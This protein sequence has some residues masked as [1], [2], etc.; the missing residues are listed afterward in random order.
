MSYPTPPPQ[1]YHQQAY[2]PPPSQP[3]HPNGQTP[4]A[5]PP[6][7]HSQY[8]QYQ[9]SVPPPDSQYGPPGQYLAQGQYGNVA[10]VGIHQAPYGGAAPY[11][12]SVPYGHAPP[13][14][15]QPLG[16]TYA[17]QPS[18]QQQLGGG[19]Y[20][21]PTPPSLG[22]IPSQ[23]VQWD[24]TQD[25]QLL[26]KAMKGFGTNEATLIAILSKRDPL[27]MAQIRRRYA[28]LYSGT[29]ESRIANE[30]SG[31]FRECLLALVRGPLDQDA[32]NVSR[33]VKG[34]GTKE[35]LLNDVLL[36]RSNADLNAI[37][38]R[39]LEIQ[40]SPLERKVSEDLSA[41]TE[42]LFAMVLAAQRAEESAPVVPQ[43]I[44]HD[45]RELQ[46]A[47][48]GRHGTDQL[49]VC[50]ILCSKSDGQLRAVANVYR[51]A[52]HRNLEDV[53]KKEFSGHMEDALLMI[54]RGGVDRAMRDATLLEKAMAGAGTKDDLL[55]NR[56]VRF[57][58]DR[59]HM[60]QVKGA[61][62]HKYGKELSS[63]IK[64]ETH[65]DYEKILLACIE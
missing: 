43:Q 21:P 63:R 4:Y 17:P 6:Q 22:Y 12:S 8:L 37:K 15:Q 64:G 53:I 44:D 16:A 39:F 41:K 24:G 18:G 40:G 56:V 38:Q 9:Q 48:E 7:A 46:K 11:S 62:R 51:S 36:S 2:G 47:T 20:F 1:G 50:H 25:A 13:P 10:S 3:T 30:T 34:L 45:V 26:H 65:G 58:W 33:A 54:L 23:V 32:Y 49:T 27:Q 28:E 5:Y 19:D 52:Y 59:N 57:H 61:Y 55:V 31:Y 35:N 29:L 42:R 60:S 14:H